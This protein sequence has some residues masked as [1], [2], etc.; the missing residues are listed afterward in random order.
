MRIGIIT[1]HASFNYG[2]M[3]QAWALQTYLRNCGYDVE[4]VNYR[5]KIQRETYHKPIDFCNKANALSSLKRILLF[6][7]SIFPLNKKWH[8]FDN[9]LHTELSLSHVVH[10]LEELYKYRWNYDLLI[11]GSDQIWNTNAPDS[12]EAYYGNWF[13]GRKIAYAASFGQYPENVKW[14]FI[15]SQ[16]NNFGAIGL[17][18]EKG[19]K[20]LLEKNTQKMMNVEVVCD[21]TLLLDVSC[22]DK[23]IDGEPLIQDDYIFFYTPVDIPYDY[24]KIAKD[25]GKRFGCKV[26][27]E[28][29]YYPKDIKRFGIEE[30]LM[31]GPREFLNLVKNA[32]YVVGG[33]FHLQVFSILMHKNFF[34][35][36]G[37]KDARTNYLLKYVGLSNRIISV[38]N[39]TFVDSPQ[40]CNWCEV[41]AK[42]KTYCNY[43]KN[44]LNLKLKDEN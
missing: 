12:G 15:N 31:V 39:P 8:L 10:T 5:S 34:C 44:W 16:L 18:E 25:L 1:F 41:D 28:K 6:P 9:F 42:L 30:Y 21:P 11:C 2:S 27:T 19:Q 36:N 35:I 32:T 17:R 20:W 23:L 14:D 24:F 29:A 7:Q 26:I 38:D 43:S 22:Y 37:D 40:I 33:S 3:L 13:H 4:I